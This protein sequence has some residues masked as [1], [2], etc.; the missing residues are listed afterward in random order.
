[1]VQCKENIFVMNCFH[2]KMIKSSQANK[3]CKYSQQS[4]LSIQLNNVDTEF[5]FAMKIANL[6][7]I[8]VR[9]R[10]KLSNCRCYTQKNMRCIVRFDKSTRQHRLSM[11]ICFGRFHILL[12][13]NCIAL[14]LSDSSLNYKVNRSL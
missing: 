8:P 13:I 4:S 1:M 10:S 3:R 2:R 7:R 5:K 14:V 12:S 6:G 11:Q 9:T